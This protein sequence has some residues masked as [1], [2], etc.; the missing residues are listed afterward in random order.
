MRDIDARA[1]RRVRRLSAIG[2]FVV[3]CLGL[4]WRIRVINGAAYAAEHAKGR[5]VVLVLWHGTMLPLLYHHRGRR[6][7]ILISEHTD[8]EI[9]ARVAERLGLS[10]V[11]GSS[12]R[13]AARAL[14]ALG[15]ALDS[16]SDVA[17]TPDGPRGPARSVAP[18]ALI[19][20]QRSG[21]PIVPLVVSAKRAWRLKTWDTFMIPKPF[22]RVTIAYGTPTPVAGE[23]AR[24]AAEDTAMLSV[25]MDDAQRTADA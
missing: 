5:S 12:S 18:G 8:G 7:A 16:G 22:S 3:R 14:V 2:A 4:T 23:S 15:R 24:S 25:L 6:I 1:E 20:A 13:G 10:L 17:I 11:R 9:I 21:A 19:A